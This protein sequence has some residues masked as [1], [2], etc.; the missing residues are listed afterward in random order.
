MNCQNCN[1]PQGACGNVGQSIVIGAEKQYGDKR[2]RKVTVW[3]CSEEC[4]VQA[5]G[6]SEYGP[7]SFRWPV[8]LDQYRT[9]FRRRANAAKKS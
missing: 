6:I 3:C 7:A 4:A 2:A 8:T 1:V 5:S 9:L